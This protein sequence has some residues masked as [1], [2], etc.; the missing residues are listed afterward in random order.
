MKIS[1][2][3][4][5]AIVTGGA[6]G[7]GR[8][9][10]VELLRAGATIVIAD[11]DISKGEALA[12]DMSPRGEGAMAVHLDVTSNDSVRR[13]I[14]EVVERTSQIDILVNNAGVFQSDLG[15]GLD[16]DGFNR[17]L[18][19]NLT[20]IWRVTREVVPHLR[21]RGGGRVINIASTGGRRGIGFAPAYCASKAGVINLTQSLASALGADGINVNAVCPGAIST[22]MREGIVA[23][24]PDH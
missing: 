17:C 6:S 18:D 10:A 8:G 11:M 1:L 7:I 14:E 4:R 5:V 2:A 20:G 15:L 3:G 16:G 13:C 19:V 24:G 23:L 22:A 12:R 9:I 21:L